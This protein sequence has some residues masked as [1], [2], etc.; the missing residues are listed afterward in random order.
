MEYNLTDKQV[1]VIIA[2]KNRP[3]LLKER[4]LASA[5]NQS[6]SPNYLIVVDDSHENIQQ[7]NKTIVSSFSHHDCHIKYLK[8][9]RTPGASGAWNTAIDHLCSEYKKSS[10]LLFLAF[11]DDDDEWHSRYL[12]RCLHAS[13]INMSNMVAAGFKRVE[14]DEY[15][16][17]LAP[18]TLKRDLF[19]IGNPGIQGSNLF[20]TFELMLMA[21]GFDENLLSCTDRDLC[22]RLSELGKVSYCALDEVLLNHYASITI[23]R[24]STPNSITKNKGLNTFW[25]KYYW[26]MNS[27]QRE[28]FLSRAKTLFNWIPTSV[29]YQP[30]VPA[31]QIGLT[32]GVELGAIS[33]ERLY[34][35]IEKIQQA[36]E[37]H[38][39]GFNV[40]LTALYEPD[41]N[42]LRTFIAFCVEQGITCYSLCNKNVCLNT[43]VAIIS[44]ENVGHQAWVLEAVEANFTTTKAFLEEVPDILERVGA[45]RLG[46]NELSRGLVSQQVAL[47]EQLKLSRI[48]AAKAQIKVLY[49][50][51]NLRLLGMGSEAIVLTDEKRVFKCID[52]WKTRVPHKQIKFLLENATQWTGLSGLYALYEVVAKGKN[53]VLTYPYEVSTAYKGGYTEQVINLLHSCSKAGI[54]CNNIHPKNLIKTQN[55]VK[56]IDYGSDIRPWSELGFEHMAR[57]AYLTIHY[58]NHPDLK[59]LLRQTLSCLDI[60][61]M[62][63]YKEFRQRLIGIDCDLKQAQTI[64]LPIPTPEKPAS[65]TLTI[66]VITGEPDK[67]LPLLN[68][69]T[70]LERQEYIQAV[71]TI[72]LCNGCSESSLK[73]VINMSKRPV[74]AIR[75]ISEQQQNKDAEAGLFGSDLTYRP[76]GQVSIAFARSMLQKYVGLACAK[77]AESYAW[78][79]D[80]DMRLDN[81]AL[82]YLPWLPK[83][84]QNGIDIIIGQYEGAS[85]NPPLNGLRGQLLDLVHN[86]RWLDTF[87]Q[88]SELPNK[89]TENDKLRNRYPDYYYDLSRKHTAHIEAPFWLEPA[90]E[91]ETVAEAKRRLIAFAPSI[92]SGYPLT[93]GI[94][95]LCSES[96]LDLLKDTVNRGGNTF[97]LNPKALTHTPNVALT[98]NGRAVRRSDMMWAIVN[99]FHHGLCIKG[100]PFPVLHTGRV[101]N[102]KMFDIEKVQDEILGSTLYAGLQD[103]LS[104]KPGHNLEF[105]AVEIDNI[106]RSTCAARRSRLSRLK[107]SFYRINGLAQSLLKYPD[108]L[109]LAEYLCK[110]FTEQTFKNIEAQVEQMT[111]QHIHN[112]LSQ[113]IKQC[114]H[115]AQEHQELEEI[116]E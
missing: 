1:A 97:I 42:D 33:F 79:L 100:A 66:G 78:I 15:F 95:P 30:S 24:L 9:N 68:S 89:S 92:L 63:G 43:A 49:G 21:G 91:G 52:Y 25:Q 26:I 14:D 39:V 80:D 55:E 20:L 57:R 4:A 87:P 50:V 16:K 88:D 11:L 70:A 114:N 86:I 59:L 69:I 47:I 75:I 102:E 56:L 53:V 107:L 83:L 5:F 22:I 90:Y 54:V 96:P 31:I 113:L 64:K 44:Q 36:A 60:P 48:N 34:A 46:E 17:S 3:S 7:Q 8:N 12:E 77:S 81:R 35:V 13:S 19:L 101:Q 73:L 23:Q 105:T 84:K 62:F 51:S 27:S 82:Q 45:Y 32:L 74:G 112:L 2:T 37:K 65:F 40:V 109:E 76:S 99:K 103:F 93:R 58:A 71:N 94:I 18:K 72:V 10:E 29:T 6:R 104:T 111:H 61:Q 41:N 116:T 106:W 28:A 110:T 108:Y 115:F 98:I 38:L 67:L 85:P